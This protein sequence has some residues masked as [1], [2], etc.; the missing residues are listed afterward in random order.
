MTHGT[1]IDVEQTN[2][3]R[4]IE[5]DQRKAGERLDPRETSEELDKDQGS[6]AWKSEPDVEN[7][8]AKE[9]KILG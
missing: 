9:W 5:N 1:K 4:G 8:M 3:K 2:E 7:R 6:C